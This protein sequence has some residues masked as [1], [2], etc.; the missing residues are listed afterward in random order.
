MG[1]LTARSRW[2]VTLPCQ[3]RSRAWVEPVT[4]RKSSPGFRPAD[5]VRFDFRSPG[6]FQGLHFALAEVV[7]LFAERF[8]V[9]PTSDPEVEQPMVVVG[10]RL[11]TGMRVNLL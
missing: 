5:L 10:F 11:R 3:A 8:A 6:A 9:A 7:V 4:R 1:S 2:P